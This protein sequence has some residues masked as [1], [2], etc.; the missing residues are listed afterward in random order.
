MSD[1]KRMF[2]EYINGLF[3]ELTDINTIFKFH[4]HLMNKK[5]DRLNELNMAPSF[6]DYVITCFLSEVI[7]KLSKLY[8]NN[9]S[10][11]NLNK[12]LNFIEQNKNIYEEC[13]GKNINNCLIDKHRQMIVDSK[14]I[15]DNLFVWRDKCYAHNDKKYFFNNQQLSADYKITVGDVEKLIELANDILDCY[16]RP[17]YKYI[18]GIDNT[19]QYDVDIVLDILHE[20]ENKKN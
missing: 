20:H 2:E 11:R 19:N 12:F 18:R 9:R 1:N 16:S 15:L 4:K 3:E 7:I 10:D 14:S 6:F 17:Y 13:E 8:E 5:K